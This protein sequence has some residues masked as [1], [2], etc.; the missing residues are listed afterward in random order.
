[1]LSE[2]FKET[3][4]VFVSIDGSDIMPHRLDTVKTASF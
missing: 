4:Q 1:L 3:V 2:N